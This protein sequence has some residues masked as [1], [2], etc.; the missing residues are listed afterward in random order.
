MGSQSELIISDLRVWS[1]V[2]DGSLNCIVIERR[3][4]EIRRGH[5]T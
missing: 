4:R 3:E 1:V 2:L 5:A